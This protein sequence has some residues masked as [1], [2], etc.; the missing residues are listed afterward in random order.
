[1]P[2]TIGIEYENCET[3]FLNYGDIEVLSP[4]SKVKGDLF[5]KDFSYPIDLVRLLQV[6]KDEEGEDPEINTE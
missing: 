5:L 6:M 2:T 3:F 4:P 1:M